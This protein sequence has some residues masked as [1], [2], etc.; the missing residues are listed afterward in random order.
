MAYGD[1]NNLR[2]E[3]LTGHEVGSK[4]SMQDATSLGQYGTAGTKH[5]G[6]PL[7]KNVLPQIESYLCDEASSSKKPL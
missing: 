1:M 5:W 2:R 7:F 3:P 4:T 6:A